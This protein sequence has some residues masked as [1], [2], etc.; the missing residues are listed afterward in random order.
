MAALLAG[1]GSVPPVA[2][3]VEAIRD[4]IAVAGIE[5]IDRMRATPRLDFGYVNDYFV[6]ASDGSRHYL[7]EFRSRCVNLRR[8]IVS[9]SMYDH[10]R[11][12]RYIRASWDTIRGCRIENIYPVPEAVLAEAQALRQG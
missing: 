4:F 8:P 6:S 12:A 11:D 3:G 10:R 1:C 9:P 2:P 5:A 7:V